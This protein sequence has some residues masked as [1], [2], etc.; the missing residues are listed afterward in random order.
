MIRSRGLLFPLVLIAIGVVVLLANLGVLSS[1]ALQRLGDLWPLLLVIVGLQLVL[2][3]TMPGQQATLAGLLAT[4]VIVIAAVAYAT[5]APANRFGTQTAD[6]SQ[7]LTG[8]NAAT[9][10]LNYSASSLEVNRSTAAD[11]LYRAHVDY[12]AGENPPTISVDQQT[13]TIEVSDSSRFS[14]FH[15]FGSNRRRRTVFLA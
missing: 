11:L 6:A 3:H 5:L 10:S 2:S 12:P 4:A 14:A 7:R 15:L 1:E 8:L 9:L 13:G